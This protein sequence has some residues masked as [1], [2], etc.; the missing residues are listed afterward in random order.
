ME[1]PGPWSTPTLKL[2][3]CILSLCWLTQLH[4]VWPRFSSPQCD[5][6]VSAPPAVL[7]QWCA[8]DKRLQLTSNLPPHVHA[9]CRC[10]ECTAGR[11]GGETAFGRF[12]A[13][14]PPAN[15]GTWCLV[16]RDP[17]AAGAYP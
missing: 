16:Y 9:T 7:P 1:A 10:V 8:S 2:Q 5:S 12:N 14:E 11:I 17:Q 4:D 3:V 6:S 15:G 13:G